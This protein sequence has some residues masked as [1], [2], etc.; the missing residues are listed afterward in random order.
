MTSNSKSLPSLT[1]SYASGINK[2][3]NAVVAGAGGSVERCGAIRR[4][5]AAVLLGDYREEQGSDA[6]DK[7]S[8]KEMG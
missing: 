3:D 7:R 8:S 6:V 4:G 2:N 5:G 1:P